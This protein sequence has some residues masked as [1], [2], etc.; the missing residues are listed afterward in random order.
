MDDAAGQVKALR[1]TTIV[2][3]AAAVYVC[4]P[5]WP[6]IVLAAWTAALAAPVLAY[7]ERGGEGRRRAAAAVSLLLFIVVLLPVALIALGVVSGA[8]DLAA[9]VAGSPSAKAALENIL[10]GNDST[11]SSSVPRTLPEYAD[12]ARQYGSQGFGVLSRVAGAATAVIVGLFIYFVGAYVFL[13]DGPAFGRWMEVNSPLAP[14]QFRRIASAFHE[15]GRGLIVGIGLTAATQGLMATITYLALGIPRWWVL[16]A[17]TGI[18]AIL[19][20]VGSA[21][22]WAPI[23]LGLLL[24]GHPVKALILVA[25]GAGIISTIDNVLRPVYAKMGSLRMPTFVLLVSIFGGIAAVGGWGVI[26]GPLVVRLFME[27]MKLRAEAEGKAPAPV[28]EG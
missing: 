3:A 27:A 24:T 5:L 9:T 14:A 16:G 15:T 28:A 23:S 6:A 20:L 12:L 10:A 2:L 17:A 1:W 21:L 8:Q 26:L 11:A 25:I 19:P 13:V 7:A 4:W 22:V 18:A